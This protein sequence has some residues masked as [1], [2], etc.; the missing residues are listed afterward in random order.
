MPGH[1]R[2][3]GSELP[4]ASDFTPFLVEERS[5]NKHQQQ[6]VRF[7]VS[8]LHLSLLIPLA[9]KHDIDC[10]Q[11]RS[12]SEIFLLFWS[13]PSFLCLLST[14]TTSS[15]AL[16]DSCL[17]SRLFFS[18]FKGGRYLHPQRLEP[19]PRTDQPLAPQAL[20]RMKNFVFIYLKKQKKTSTFSFFPPLQ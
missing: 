16:I 3:R 5:E 2:G 10:K 6:L 12:S 9:D 15:G 4:G 8:C 19:M 18:V 11:T 7:T 13:P 20:R 17:L 1:I 14:N